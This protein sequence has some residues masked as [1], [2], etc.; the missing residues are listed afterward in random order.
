MNYALC[1]IN[2]KHLLDSLF[3][4]FEPYLHAELAVYVLCQVLG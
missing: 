4:V 1:I 2:R 3:P